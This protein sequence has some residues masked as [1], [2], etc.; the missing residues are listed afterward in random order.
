MP[1]K[2][3]RATQPEIASYLEENGP[4]RLTKLCKHFGRKKGTVGNSL[5]RMIAKGTA[6]R[7]SRG[8]YEV[9]EQN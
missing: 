3:R 2:E 6:K 5:S 1:A 7:V 4:T 8:V 9:A